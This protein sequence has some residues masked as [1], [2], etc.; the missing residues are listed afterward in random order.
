M[1]LTAKTC[2]PCQGGIPPLTPAEAEKYLPEV[3]GWELTEG[4]TK[5]ERTFKFDN[6]VV[7]MAFAQKVGGLAEAEGH[8]PELTISW[9]RCRVMFQTRK[10]KGLHEN[11]FI[12]AAKVNLL[13]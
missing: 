2:T 8:H 1:S 7:A 4:A 9:G 10:I 12:I 5:L 13:V 6:F 11:D 3:P